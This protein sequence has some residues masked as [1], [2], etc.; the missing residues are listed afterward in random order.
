VFPI[1]AQQRQHAL[2]MLLYK[3]RDTHL[4]RFAVIKVLPGEKF[5]DARRT[6]RRSRK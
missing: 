6:T 4:G 3:A 1:A 5:A 2:I